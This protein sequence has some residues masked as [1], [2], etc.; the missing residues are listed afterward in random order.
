MIIWFNGRAPELRVI[1]CEA[2][3]SIPQHHK[4]K[5]ANLREVALTLIRLPGAVSLETEQSCQSPSGL[6]HLDGSMSVKTGCIICMACGLESSMGW[7]PL[8]RVRVRHVS[9]SSP[10]GTP[11]SWMVCFKAQLLLLAVA[12]G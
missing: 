5:Q 1:M 8:P 3:G 11:R 7:N 9:A 10:V 6:M 4:H 2:L 12:N